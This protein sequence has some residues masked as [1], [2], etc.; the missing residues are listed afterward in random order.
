MISSRKRFFEPLDQRHMSSDDD[1]RQRL[2]KDLRRAVPNAV[3]F[4]ALEKQSHANLPCRK[5]VSPQS[6]FM[7]ALAKP[8]VSL[9]VSQ[10]LCSLILSDEDVAMLE[11]ST[12][13]QSNS[14]IWAQSRIGRITASNFYA[15]HTKVQSMQSKPDTSVESLLST[16]MGYARNPETL[17]AL[18]Y[19]R[20]ME[21]EAKKV[22]ATMFS[23]QHTG[24]HCDPV[25]LVLSPHKAYLGASPDALLSCQC[26][27]RG[28]LEIKC[29]L[30]VKD[31]PPTPACIPYLIDNGQVITLKENHAY[32][33]QCQGQMALTGC[34]WCSFF[35]FSKHGHINLTV[36]FDQ[37]YWEQMCESLDFFFENCIA[38]ELFTARLK[39]KLERPDTLTHTPAGSSAHDSVTCTHVDV[40]PSS[41]KGCDVVHASHNKNTVAVQDQYNCPVCALPCKDQ[42]TTFRE[43]SVGCDSC[44]KW[45]HFTCVGIKNSAQVRRLPDSW[46]CPSCNPM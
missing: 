15:V 38:P 30:S 6:L 28:V 2:A 16:L 31:T 18:K 29:P 32:Y 14:P 12:R 11:K 44:N 37:T 43:G 33:A 39:L 40:V 17:P 42:C 4:T 23:K 21:L 22:F 26:H 27:G 5:L 19:G 25:G 34:E 10:F 24:A 8:Y 35:I 20:E 45:Y 3:M 9:S 36:H 13:G 41:A 7:H 1:S 46:K